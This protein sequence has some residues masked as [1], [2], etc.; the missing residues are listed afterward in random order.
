MT[1][2]DEGGRQNSNM[3]SRRTLVGA[4]AIGAGATVAGSP[5]A[6]AQ[7]ERGMP[8]SVVT[9][10]PRD[11]GPNA[12]PNTYLDPDIVTVDPLFAQYVQGTRRSNAC[13]PARSGQRAR[14]GALRADTWC[15]AIFQTIAS[16][17]GSKTM[18]ASASS[19]CRR[20]IATAIRL[21]SRAAR[22]P[23]SI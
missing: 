2:Q 10:P 16:C 3:L 14:P 13:G 1:R 17:A 19:A 5:G 20:T 21:I 23:A 6:M 12:A 7:A 8:S 18:V 9:S 4:I 15:G 11:F 22:C